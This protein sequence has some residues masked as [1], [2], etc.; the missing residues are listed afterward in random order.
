MPYPNLRGALRLSLFLAL[1]GE[2]EFP[3]RA[4]AQT[5]GG[6]FELHQYQPSPFSDR[7]L[8]LDGTGVQPFGEYRL[9]IDLDYALRPLVLVDAMPGIFQA[10]E[11]GPEHHLVEHAA[12]ASLAAS[13]GLGHGLEIAV[14]LPLTLYQAGD[15]VP[16]V[17]TPALVGVGNPRLGV[18]ARLFARGGFGFGAAVLLTPPVGLGSLA[19]EKA[20][21][22]EG[23][24]F[25]DFERGRFSVGGRASLRLRNRVDFYDVTV[26]NELGVAAGGSLR[27]FPR[28]YLLAELAGSTAAAA[29]LTNLRQSP[30]EVLV[31][32]RQRVGKN[33]FTVAAGPGLTD[34][35]GS[36]VFRLVAGWTWASRPP[37][38]DHDGVP[39]DDDRCPTIPEDKDGFE[40]ADGCPD[41]DNDKD[42]ILDPN[43]RCPDQAED[44]DGFEDADG[45]P[46]PDNDKDGILDAQD[47][48]PLEPET[49]NGLDDEDG[50]PDTVAVAVDTDKDGIMDEED[51]CPEEPEDKDGFEDE[52]GCP[53]PDNDKDGILDAQDKCPLEPETINGIDD[54]DGCP[55]KGKPEVRLG[56]HEIETLKPIFFATDRARVRHAFYSL[57]GQIASLMKAH[58]EIGRVAVEGHTDDTGPADWNQRLSMRRAES[59]VAFLVGRGIERERLVPV[60]QAE[61]LP[62]A[63]NETPWGRAKNRRVVFHVE[64]ANPV[65]EKK[66]EQRRERRRHIHHRHAPPG[67]DEAAS[68][69]PHKDAPPVDSGPA[70]ETSK[71]EP[72]E[73][74][75][76]SVA[77]EPSGKG[78]AHG[79]QQDPKGERDEKRPSKSAVVGSGRTSGMAAAELAAAV[80]ASENERLRKAKLE[81][82]EGPVSDDGPEGKTASGDVSQKNTARH[83]PQGPPPRAVPKP[84]WVG[85]APTLRE[86]LVLPPK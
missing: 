8:R 42:G 32:L 60:G 85:P 45:C 74:P 1:V 83:R 55:D 7:V 16:G 19:Y 47:K 21:G 84:L 76:K 49:V 29:P 37:D 72:H 17:T 10:G 20:F 54:E 25:A 52:D 27:L 11:P 2:G 64:G 41:P 35:Y 3:G 38:V 24:V 65:E 40:D 39:D 26:G 62:W 13:L 68:A 9:G 33:W 23:R 80:K 46:D 51:E 75:G 28:T 63:S 66:Q 82:P 73:R 71:P 12:S 30:V 53:D 43:D 79:R 15:S 56:A 86:M 67:D 81:G 6:Q 18:K 57:L 36:P 14:G 48:C 31:G 69:P 58:P 44:K 5:T 50:C 22:G 70:S 34:G 77:D 59:V 4:S 78:E 61:K